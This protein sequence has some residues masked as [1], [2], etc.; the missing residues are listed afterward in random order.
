[1][2]GMKTQECHV[3]KNVSCREF[4]EKKL[5]FDPNSPSVTWS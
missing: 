1:M 5:G 3:S 2:E 4:Y